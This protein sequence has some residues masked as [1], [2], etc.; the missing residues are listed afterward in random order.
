M[1]SEGYVSLSIFAS[2]LQSLP[3]LIL[4]LYIIREKRQIFV[5]TSQ[6]YSTERV[7]GPS[8]KAKFILLVSLSLLCFQF[9]DPSI[10]S[11]F[12]TYKVNRGNSS[13]SFESR[14]CSVPPFW[15]H[16]AT[17]IEDK[18]SYYDPVLHGWASWVDLTQILGFLGSCL[19]FH[20]GRL[21][22]RRNKEEWIRVVV[23]R[24][25]ETFDFR[26]Y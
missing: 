23:T 20:Y 22:F 12:V 7:V 5:A 13:I 9:L 11:K 18:L 19:M 25:Q 10:M 17:V 16:N 3:I 8:L 1:Y 21:E 14:M 2:I 4:G 26:R 6:N 15:W 24:V